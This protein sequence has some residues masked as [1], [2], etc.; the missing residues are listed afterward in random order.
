MKKNMF[1][2]LMLFTVIA[3]MTSCY[4]GDVATEDLDTVTTLR[5]GDF[6]KPNKVVIWWG[7]HQIKG[8]GDD[9]I[10]Y[11]GE[12]DEEILN[13]TLDNLV[14][15]YGVDN[16]YI[17]NPDNTPD[18]TPSKPVKVITPN[19]VPPTGVDYKIFPAII[20]KENISIGYYPPYW[21]PWYPWY[22]CWYC[23]YPPVYD[24][25]SYEVGTVLLGMINNPWGVSDDDNGQWLAAVRGLL[26]SSNSFNG[27]RTVEGI[28]KAFDQS[29]YLK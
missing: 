29:P 6:N 25:S 19:D 18:P 27:S 8:E 22:P 17:F 4:P 16:V 2:F 7:V 13:T 1:K 23:W 28:N 24:I 10:P 9:N 21:D 26:S 15:L 14:D 5:T 3:L 12:I 11:R 20:L